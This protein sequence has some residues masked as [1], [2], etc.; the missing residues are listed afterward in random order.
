[1][2]I[3]LSLA[4]IDGEPRVDSRI[5]IAELGVEPRATRQL[6]ERYFSDFKEFGQLPFEMEVVNGHQGG[7]NPTKFYLLNED[8]TYFLMTLVRN[9]PEAVQLKKRLVKAFAQFRM[10]ANSLELV[11]APRLEIDTLRAQLAACHAYI[12]QRVPLMG[13]LRRY[14]EA[15][16]SQREIAL[17]CGWVSAK[18]VRE[19]LR[20]A[21]R[22]GLLP[23]SG[24]RQLSLL[25]G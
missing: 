6:I 19:R 13:K 15:G 14:R 16:L 17:L 24:S 11:P 3:A 20:Q 12:A 5:V 22:L 25:E 9:T 4:V 23:P 1:M 8:Q 21:E 2:S 10:T 18:S 7:G